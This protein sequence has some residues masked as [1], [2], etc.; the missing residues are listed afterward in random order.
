MTGGHIVGYTVYFMDLHIICK[1]PEGVLIAK[2]VHVLLGTLTTFILRVRENR[3]F[4]R[5][6][7]AKVGYYESKLL[8]TLQLVK[9][10][11]LLPPGPA[12]EG[13]RTFTFPFIGSSQIPWSWSTSL[14]L[15][16]VLLNWSFKKQAPNAAAKFPKVRLCESQAPGEFSRKFRQSSAKERANVKVHFE[17]SGPV[18]LA[19]RNLI[20]NNL[21]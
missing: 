18:S 7:F 10:Y 1:Q 20:S 21:S 2:T 6:S 13:Y 5:E 8:Y 17:G 19:K 14:D 4:I 3:L 9:G 16:L 12:G 15:L 11:H